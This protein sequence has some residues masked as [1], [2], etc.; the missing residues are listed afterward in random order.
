MGDYLHP[1]FQKLDPERDWLYRLELSLTS[2]GLATGLD[3]LSINAS[4]VSIP[5]PVA[6]EVIVSQLNQD[7]KFSGRATLADMTVTFFTAYNQDAVE[8]LEQWGRKVFDPETEVMGYSEEYKV[9]GDFIVLY[10]NLTP[11]KLYKLKGVFPKDI[12]TKEYGWA[13][14]AN[15]T[16]AVTFSIDKVLEP[17][18]GGKYKEGVA[19]TFGA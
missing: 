15:V 19:P 11:F 4:T 2:I 13:N 17:S 10:P 12:G 16:R 9:D 6:G 8:I 5:S 18:A 3:V 14:T 7:V 1:Y